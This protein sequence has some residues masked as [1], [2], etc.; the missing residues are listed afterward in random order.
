MMEEYELSICIPTYN[1]GMKLVECVKEILAYKGKEVEVVISDNAS[2]D[3][4][5]DRLREI[6]DDRLKIYVNENNVGPFRNWYLALSRGSGRYVMLLQDN[7]HLVT[8]NLPVYLELLRRT[9]CDVMRNAYANHDRVSGLISGAK[10]LYYSEI[11]SHGSYIVY[12]RDA[13]KSITPWAKSLDC[14]FTSYPWLIWDL[15]ILYQ[16]PLYTKH[17]YLNG[18]IEIV[19][20][21]SEEKKGRYSR[22]RS[23]LEG[24]N[25]PPSYTYD[26]AVYYW[27][28]NE[29]LLRE[30]Y[31]KDRDYLSVY[32]SLYRGFLYRATCG[33]YDHMTDEISRVRYLVFV[34]DKDIDYLKLNDTFLHHALETVHIQKTPITFVLKLRMITWVNRLWFKLNY[35]YDRRFSNPKYSFGCLLYKFAHMCL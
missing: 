29:P 25:I 13:F 27:D 19:R 20:P 8:E 24:M 16:Y 6:E 28:K 34:E 4:C 7:D 22:T 3:G 30:L 18:K 14:S 35:V 32:L 5:I 10:W 1:G 33:F 23:N 21:E 12:R 9:N 17:A 26:N 2:E 15:E 11:Y 31:C